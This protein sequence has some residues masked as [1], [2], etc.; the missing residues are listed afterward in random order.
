MRTTFYH[1]GEELEDSNTET[2]LIREQD[3]NYFI[4]FLKLYHTFVYNFT[5][6]ILEEEV[7]VMEFEFLWMTVL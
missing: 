2:C 1:T 3:F 5:L 6:T 4:K 7:K